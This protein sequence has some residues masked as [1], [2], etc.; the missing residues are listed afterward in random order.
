MLRRKLSSIMAAGTDPTRRLKRE[1]PE[2]R[3]WAT[4]A[5]TL[6]TPLLLAACAGPGAPPAPS[7]SGG[8]SLTI[9]HIN[10]HHSHLD[11]SSFPLP[12]KLIGRDGVIQA[13]I[14]GFPRIAAAMQE[15][16]PSNGAVLRLHAGDAITGDLYYSLTEGAADAR[17]MNIVCFDAFTLGNHEFDHGDTKLRKFLELLAADACK[18]PVLSANVE[19]GMDSALH[20]SRA[21]GMV[22]PSVVVERGGHKIGIIGVT[23]ADKT[24]RSSQPDPGTRFNNE[25]KA[26]Q[27]Q[28]NALQAQGVNRIVVLSHIGYG[29][30]IELAQ[31]LHGVDAI[32]GGDSH[33]LLGPPSLKELGLKPQAAYPVIARNADQQ[34]VC[35]VQA[36]Q[37]AHAV[38]RLE[39]DFDPEGNVMA[40]RGAPQLLLADDFR[41]NGQPLNPAARRTLLNAIKQNESLRLTA[42]DKA[43]VAA[44][45][46]F[47]HGKQTTGQQRV[48]LVLT[49]LCAQRLPGIIY[50]AAGFTPGGVCASDPHAMAH[51]GDAQQLVVHA[52]LERSREQAIPA[53]LALINGGSVRID[54]PPGPI[55]MANVHT[56]LP[57]PNTLTRLTMSGAALHSVLEEVIDTLII[58]RSTG[59]YPYAAGLSWD[60]DL[61]QP[62]GKRFSNLRVLG[63]DGS[64]QPLESDRIYR[65]ITLDYLANGADGYSGFAAITGKDRLNTGLPY[66]HAFAE[67]LRAPA[68]I[69]AGIHRLPTK[70]YSTRQVIGPRN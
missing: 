69:D 55:T 48:G 29:H 18:T 17:L 52:F 4:R 46:P 59:G 36:W 14:G 39:V 1:H 32:V 68:R 15:L 57:F 53:D 45:A 38:G 70:H 54:L 66:A 64:W 33:S 67:Y 16:A 23:I 43:A 2:N 63:A 42:P 28:I 34:Q 65:V 25:R 62:R 19:F 26:V 7:D 56:L 37:H 60:L 12:A 11:E 51:G 5:V 13:K 50:E 61:R 20:P 40:C 44:L 41:W 22:R 30:D 3:A 10:D 21:P 8:A 58:R 27:A 31:S 35:I 6:L 47:Q 24:M 9:L 49:P